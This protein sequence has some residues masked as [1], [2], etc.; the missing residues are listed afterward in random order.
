M[1]VRATLRHSGPSC[2]T[3]ELRGEAEC[4]SWVEMCEALYA[5]NPKSDFRLGGQHAPLRL[6]ILVRVYGGKFM[7]RQGW[8]NVRLGLTNQDQPWGALVSG[9]GGLHMES[10]WLIAG[11]AD[12]RLFALPGEYAFA[13]TS[14]TTNLALDMRAKQCYLN[15]N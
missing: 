3:S 15:L 7:R 12:S 11:M 5:T 6:R 13:M 14:P 8:E 10:V 1:H 2:A 4:S 9:A